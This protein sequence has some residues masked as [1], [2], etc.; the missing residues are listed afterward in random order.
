MF[1]T[2]SRTAAHSLLVRNVSECRCWHGFVSSLELAE[3]DS[4][5]SAIYF[6]ENWPLTHP[7]V[8][9]CTC[10][11]NQH[12]WSC[13]GCSVCRPSILATFLNLK[14]RREWTED[15]NGRR[16]SSLSRQS[17]RSWHRFPSPGLR[18]FE[19]QCNHKFNCLCNKER[20]LAGLVF[21]QS[22]T[23]LWSFQFLQLTKP[24]PRIRLKL[25]SSCLV[26]IN[27]ISYDCIN[28]TI[29]GWI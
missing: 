21:G 8:G 23:G 19:N 5:R 7:F 20:D 6:P 29:I 25:K 14:A 10:S 24:W 18:A 4:A 1:L 13:G 16:L 17:L 27:G 3:D 2:K 28:I 22:T 11:F 26:Y 12:I 9:H 15:R